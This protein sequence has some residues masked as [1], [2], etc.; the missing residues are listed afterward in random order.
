MENNKP[1]NTIILLTVALMLVFLFVIPRYRE[2]GRVELLLL[3][4]QVEYDSQSTYYDHIANILQQLNIKKGSL[5]KIDNALPSDILLSPLIY[6]FQKEG[7]ANGITIA[8]VIFSKTP[9]SINNQ[10]GQND[11]N[12]TIK[13]I[14]L[15]V[16]GSGTYSGLRKFMESV[17]AS[18][19]LFQIDVVSLKKVAGV[20]SGSI[21]IKNQLPRYD[22]TLNIKA[23]IYQ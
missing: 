15:V 1:L 23:H 16:E 13:D 2:L 5:G 12:R 9:Q 17:E 14:S 7:S 3:E 11:M 21:L 10:N 18:S 22:I 19:R 20:S 6:F 8:S 4:K